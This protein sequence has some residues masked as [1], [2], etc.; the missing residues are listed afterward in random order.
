[1]ASVDYEDA[2]NRAMVGY[3]DDT[4]QESILR[5]TEAQVWATLAVVAELRAARL[6]DG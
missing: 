5:A 2:A 6:A 1:M 4:V 3:P